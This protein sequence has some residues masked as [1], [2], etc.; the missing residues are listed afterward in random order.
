VRDR[1][2]PAADRRAHELERQIRDLT[3]MLALPAMW[4][5]RDRDFILSGLVQVLVSLLRVDVVC[6]W[7]GGNEPR[8]CAHVEG[9]ALSP[10]EVAKI[11]QAVP[12]GNDD[13]IITASVP[14]VGPVRL[15]RL[16]FSVLDEIGSVTVG[17]TRAEFPTAAERFLLRAA[18]NQTAIALE[19]AEH[20][21][22]ARASEDRYR[23]Q[24]RVTETLN[25]VGAAVASELDRRTIVQTV[26]DAATELT[27]A[28]FGAFF[29]NVVDPASGEAFPLYTL[30]GASR[31]AFEGFPQPRATSLFGPTFRG[32]SI[33]RL[34]DVLQD[35]RDG[36]NPPFHG[37]PSGHLP[38]RSYLAVPVKTRDGEVL[39]G[40]FFG[41]PDVGVFSEEHERLA[42]GVAAWASVAL[43]NARLYEQAQEANRAKD[44]F[45]AI[46][47][48]EL[49]TPLNAIAGWVHM[50]RDGRAAGETA[51]H[52]LKVIERNVR[53]QTQLIEDL[54]DV[55]RVVS[56][57]LR[58]EMA[59]TDLTAVVRSA[60]D[61]VRPAL[62]DK[63]IQLELH[64]DPSA[65]QVYGDPSRLE[66][67]VWNLLTNAA[68]FTPEGGRIEVAVRS[69]DGR[70]EVTVRDN[71][72]GIAPH[73]L[74]HI[75]DRFRQAEGG[76]A[77]K[78][79]GLGL[80]L[81]LVKA[82]THAHGGTVHA[83]SE[84]IGKGA[85]FSVGLPTVTEFPLVEAPRQPQ[86][87][88]RV[89][90]IG[91]RALVVDDEAD[92]RELVA[93][94]LRS[95]GAEPV[96]AGSVTEA[97]EAFE[98][99]RPDVVIAD[100]GMPG[101]DGYDLIRAIRMNAAHGEGAT[102]AIALTAF[103]SATERAEIRQAGYDAHVAK[104]FDLDDLLA[105]IAR[106]VHRA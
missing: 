50:L 40:L 86:T 82:L 71:G 46:L 33:V 95:A 75:F 41:H 98:R 92:G 60:L 100:I 1:E 13:S 45:L 70:A 36:Q 81:T 14:P 74:P 51:T 78:H 10:G 5:G 21:R 39:G 28:A 96:V 94:T 89:P 53:R 102:P 67:I 97:L 76:P 35:A 90:I 57:K 18:V 7:T 63:N 15:T 47:S 55:S 44:E 6:A 25:R 29:Y 37:T 85:T 61:A 56:G 59:A 91:V 73:V 68:K 101:Q 80:G 23:A 65:A 34:A 93:E 32:E 27:T 11:L 38:V 52:A 19:T 62:A 87:A 12:F 69:R 31:E 58:L 104:P 54:L 105:T 9:H 4:K 99:H 66:Q 48:H 79:G 30:S 106:L 2:T 103:A 24:V 16:G 77:R 20:V 72:Q 42:S 43:E 84:G 22:L 88:A 26:T 64:V 3:A 83:A 17:S 8:E 49:R